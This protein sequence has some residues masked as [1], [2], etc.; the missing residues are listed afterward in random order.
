MKEFLVAIA[1]NPNCGK[2]T[3]FNKLTGSTQ[4]VANYPGVTVEQK[5]GFLIYEDYRITIVDLP[6]LYSFDTYSIDENIAKNFLIQKKPDIILNVVDSSNLQRHLFLTTQLMEL[7]VPL[8][9]VLNMVDVAKKH[10]ICVDVDFLGKLLEVKVIPVISSKN[11]GIDNLISAIVTHKDIS[12]KLKF[13]ELIENELFFIQNYLNQTYLNQT[14]LNQNKTISDATKASIRWL[15]VKLLEGDKEIEKFFPQPYLN[16]IKT[17]RKSFADK[18]KE[19]FEISIAKERH[20]LILQICQKVI[21][22]KNVYERKNSSDYIDDWITNK[23]FG[24]P[25]FLLFMFLTFKVTFTCGGFC[26]KWLQ[27]FFQHFSLF[28]HGHI[29]HPLLRSLTVDGILAGVGSVVLFLPNIL[30]L[31]I[32]ISI[33][34]QSG[35]MARAAFIMDKIM[36]KMG[37]HGK[38]FIPMLIGFGC[39]VPAIMATRTLENKRDRFSVILALPLIVCSAKLVV[40]TIIIPSFFPLVW[41]PWVLLFLYCMSFILAVIVIKLLKVTLFKGDNAPFIM[42]LPPYHMP[43]WKSIFLETWFMAGQYLKK[44]GTVIFTFAIVLWILSSFPQKCEQQKENLSCSYIGKIGKVIEPIFAPLGFDWKIDTAMMSA[45]A[46][47]EVFVTQMGIIFSKE[48][49]RS[50][51]EGLKENYSAL[52]AFCIMLFMLVSIPCMTTIAITKKET[53]SWK[54]AIF[55]LGGLLI[56]A[57]TITLAVY[58]LGQ[59]VM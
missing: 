38:S 17:R 14:K 36:H 28:L 52:Q 50:V 35:Y 16:E 30:F 51:Q 27:I 26:A 44:A 10:E 4:H 7:G 19:D 41:Q 39:T 59:I 54:W 48:G 29:H 47:K 24:I 40:F 13:S 33:L 34:E 53:G 55:Q 12:A 49:K 43:S 23:Y 9:V 37:L 2:T 56:I 32:F 22:S 45:I 3:I 15:A 11:I 42:E 57:Y 25:I 5:E 21:K 31:F 1:G 58:Q 18:N 20:A 46:A 8:I 6:G